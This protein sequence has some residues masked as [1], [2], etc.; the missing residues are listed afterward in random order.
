MDKERTYMRSLLAILLLMILTGCASTGRTPQQAG[1]YGSNSISESNLNQSQKCLVKYDIKEG[2]ENL[3]N[4]LNILIEAGCNVRSDISLSQANY[5]LQYL[6]ESSNT[7]SCYY[8]FERSS[9]EDISITL[10]RIRLTADNNVVKT[11]FIA[12]NEQGCSPKP[13]FKA[14]SKFRIEVFQKLGLKDK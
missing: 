9:K 2:Q 13:Y 14:L 11:I 6:E 7:P 4:I 1:D 10:S 12:A 8:R 5:Y 3:D